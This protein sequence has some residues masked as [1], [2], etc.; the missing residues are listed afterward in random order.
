MV[1]QARAW[2]ENHQVPADRLPPSVLMAEVTELRRHLAAVL[3]IAEQAESRQLAEIR[4]LLAGFDWEYH[5][6]QL[7]LEEIQRILNGQ[8]PE[9]MR[10]M[11]TD[12]LAP[13]T[14]EQWGV[15]PAADELAE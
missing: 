6:R 7:A 8:R 12:D 2:I 11:C 10:P 4:Q 1:A 5:D 9:P 14:G 3:A 13:S 15:D